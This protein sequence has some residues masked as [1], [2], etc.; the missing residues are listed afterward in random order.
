MNKEYKFLIIDIKKDI[1]YFKIENE[2]IYIYINKNDVVGFKGEKAYFQNWVY[3]LD[4]NH[5]LDNYNF[6]SFLRFNI[7]NKEN[8]VLYNPKTEQKNFKNFKLKEF[9]YKEE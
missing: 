8:G 4:L 5:Y 6:K 3:D 7:F 9:V 2:P 1:V